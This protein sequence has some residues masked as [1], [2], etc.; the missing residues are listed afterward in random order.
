M[1]TKMGLEFKYVSVKLVQLIM[2]IHLRSVK[3]SDID[4]VVKIHLRSFDGFLLAD[5]GESFLTAMYKSYV[6]QSNAAFFV[7]EDKSMIVGFAIGILPSMER[8]SVFG[9]YYKAVMMINLIM[10]IIA[11]PKLFGIRILRRMI[12]YRRHV[13]I[14]EGCAFLKSI[15]VLVSKNSNGIGSKLLEAF[16]TKAWGM[17]ADSIQLTT[18]RHHND[19]AIGFYKKNRYTI[20]LE[21]Q[22][23][24]NRGMCLMEKQSEKQ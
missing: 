13:I 12:A 10:Q 9:S 23:D 17:G 8:F 11:H 22:Q 19:R 18:D 6:Y 1:V 21:F 14:K 24:R 7:A 20:K 4:A 3:I 2:A 16:E 5:L 15:A